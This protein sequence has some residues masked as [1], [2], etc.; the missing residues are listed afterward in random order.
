MREYFIENRVNSRKLAVLEDGNLVS[1]LISKNKI[2]SKSMPHSSSILK[3]IYRGKVKKIGKDLVSIFIE[4]ENGIEGYLQLSGKNSKDRNM[5]IGDTVMVQ[6]IKESVGEK[7][8]VLSEEISIP[9]RYLVYI[10]KNSRNVFSSKIESNDI[11]RNL[12]SCMKYIMDKNDI[13]GGFIVRERALEIDIDTLESEAIKLKNI[14]EKILSKYKNKSEAEMIYS[15]KDKILE[16]IE[17]NFDQ[18][19]E[20]IHIN[21]SYDEDIRNLILDFNPELTLKIKDHKGGD[22][23]EEEGISYKISN[24]LKRKIEFDKGASIV[25]DKTEAMTVIDVNSGAW[26]IAS[27]GMDYLLDIN[28]KAMILISDIIKARDITGIIIIDFI[29]MKDKSSYKKLLDHSQE[30]MKKDDRKNNVHGFTRLGLMEIT[31]MRSGESID[32]YYVS[33]DGKSIDM[34]FDELEGYVIRV[35][36]NIDRYDECK[37]L[38]IEIPKNIRDRIGKRDNQILRAIEKRYSIKLE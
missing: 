10:P 21:R 12:G 35:L 34:I 3:N 16:Y 13:K 8:P 17:N 31:R 1:L 29:N 20:K 33:A 18:N 6:V 24:L 28:K 2:D 26:N 32:S 14:Y 5:H 22:I 37:E 23:F 11:K 7:R 30:I 19:V 15:H 9:S 27:S 36:N 38:A 25:V 4:L